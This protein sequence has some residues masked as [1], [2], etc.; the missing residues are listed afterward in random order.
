MGNKQCDKEHIVKDDWEIIKFG[1]NQ[2]E[3]LRNRKDH[4]MCIEEYYLASYEK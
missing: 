2:N 1:L 3:F 4:Q